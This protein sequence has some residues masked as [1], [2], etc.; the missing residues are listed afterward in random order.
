EFLPFRPT[1][2]AWVN[3]RLRQGDILRLTEPQFVNGATA[4]TVVVRWI[5]KQSRLVRTCLV[6]SDPSSFLDRPE[7]ARLGPETLTPDPHRLA[8]GACW[9]VPEQWRKIYVT[10][11]PVVA[12][13]WERLTG[14][15]LRVGPHKAGPGPR[16]RRTGLR[17]IGSWFEG[18]WER[19]LN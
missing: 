10:I 5:W 11:W 9:S 1:I 4:A 7:E 12:L 19:V 15:P 6:A 3:D 18:I 16:D 14:P 17:R 2:T 13:G 8:G